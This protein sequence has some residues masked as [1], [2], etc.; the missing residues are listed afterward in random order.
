[1]YVCTSSW[2]YHVNT[3][4]GVT[5]AVGT[6]SFFF[7]YKFKNMGK[8]KSFQPGLEACTLLNRDS[9]FLESPQHR[10]TKHAATTSHV[11]TELRRPNIDTSEA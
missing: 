11:S 1:M 9:L 7:P 5:S 6:T 4:I 3:W 10:D 2:G 8:K